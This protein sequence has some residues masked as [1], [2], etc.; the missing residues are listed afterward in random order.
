MNTCQGWRA[1]I[2]TSFPCTF[3]SFRRGLYY[4]I[5]TA[6]VDSAWQRGKRRTCG[7]IRPALAHANIIGGIE[8]PERDERGQQRVGTSARFVPARHTAGSLPVYT[9]YT[10]QNTM[11]ISLSP[12]SIVSVGRPPP[13]YGSAHGK[14]QR[15]LARNHLVTRR[16]LSTP[17]A[18]PLTSR[19]RCS[20][21]I[22]AIRS[23]RRPPFLILS[24]L[25]LLRFL[26]FFLIVVVSV[27]ENIEVWK[28]F[29]EWKSFFL[30]E[31]IFP[32][33]YNCGVL[34]RENIPSFF[35][36]SN[37]CQKSI[38]SRLISRLKVIWIKYIL[39]LLKVFF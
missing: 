9:G 4:N 35:Q 18:Y 15:P 19:R 7:G 39:I 34:L 8:W 1:A 29:C 13:L 37:F 32:D 12:W 2:I 10:V 5:R 14:W 22:H 26:F 28:S 24:D 20:M 3:L 17:S 31:N 36:N 38:H 25:H 33:R 30:S 27:G 21:Q 16:P 6:H 11:H 23:L